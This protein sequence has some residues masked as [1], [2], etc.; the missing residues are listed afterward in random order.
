MDSMN[1]AFQEAS[2]LGKTIWCS[3]GDNGSSDLRP[4]YGGI[5]DNLAHVHFPATEVVE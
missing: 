1:E 4:Q 3:T 5:K 2:A